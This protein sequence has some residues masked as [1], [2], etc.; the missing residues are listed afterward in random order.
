MWIR[1]LVGFLRWRVENENENEKKK[2]KENEFLLFSLLDESTS[3]L[4]ILCG[5]AFHLLLLA[6][7]LL[8]ALAIVTGIN[9]IK[10]TLRVTK[11]RP[12]RSRG[13]VIKRSKW[14]TLGNQLM[15]LLIV[16][17]RV[18]LSFNLRGWGKGGDKVK[19]KKKKC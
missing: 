8:L 12:L 16:N 7:F 2:K 4:Q 19:R 17:P 14:L 10:P 6:I 13:S 18:P 11:H 1:F 3:K 5:A 9:W 15:K